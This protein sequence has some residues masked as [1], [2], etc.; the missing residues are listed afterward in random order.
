MYYNNN[1]VNKK[2]VKKDTIS[3]LTR[4]QWYALVFFIIIF[5]IF[6]PYILTYTK[7]YD[8]LEMYFPN[9]D[10]IATCFSLNNGPYNTKIFQHLY[11][12]DKPFVGYMS[13]NLIGLISIIGIFVVVFKKIKS[14]IK[15]KSK[16]P[17]MNGLSCAIIMLIITFFFPNRYINVLT[18]YIYENLLK[19]FSNTNDILWYVT[20]F[21]GIVVSFL[22]I[23][24]ESKINNSYIQK[25]LT[26]KIINIFNHFN[27][28]NL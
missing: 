13:T 18:H 16:H 26:K 11:L 27:M 23:K 3:K 2:K 12:S 24:L 21:I 19:N 7:N 8:I 28:E 9:L 10:L 14:L 5:A 20:V 4:Y 17:F 25:I 6:I 15:E 1:K 22:I